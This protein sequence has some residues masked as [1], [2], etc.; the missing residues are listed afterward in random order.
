MINL[1]DANA[2]AAGVQTNRRKGPRDNV[3]GWYAR[4]T[5]AWQAATERRAAIWKAKGRPVPMHL[6]DD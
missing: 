3:I 5:A 2:T 4:L 1:T 6:G